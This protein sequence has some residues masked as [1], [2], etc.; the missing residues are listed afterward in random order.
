MSCVEVCPNVLKFFWRENVYTQ[1]G[2]NLRKMS[3]KWFINISILNILS[4][5]SLFV[6]IDEPTIKLWNTIK[7]C[8]N[9]VI[10]FFF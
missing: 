8:F 3:F 4:Q 7:F 5:G 9:I 1:Q 10:N 6:V 2:W